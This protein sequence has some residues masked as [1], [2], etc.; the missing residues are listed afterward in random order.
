MRTFA[1]FHGKSVRGSLGE[2]LGEVAD[3]VVD[4]SSG[5]IPY[6]LVASRIAPTEGYRLRLV[7]TGALKESERGDGL[8]VP[9]QGAQ[10]RGLES[11]DARQLEAGALRAFEAH[12]QELARVFGLTQAGAPPSRLLLATHLL[13]KSVRHGGDT[14]GTLKAILAAS[15]RRT[16][17][18]L[19]RMVDSSQPRTVRVRLTEL[20]LPYFS[21][22]HFTTDLTRQE[23]ENAPAADINLTAALSVSA[24]VRQILNASMLPQFSTAGQTGYAISPV[25]PPGGP[26]PVPVPPVADTPPSPSGDDRLTPTGQSSAQSNTAAIEAALAAVRRALQAEPALQGSSVEVEVRAG[27]VV[28]RGKVPN[29]EL[30]QRAEAVAKRTVPNVPLDNEIVVPPR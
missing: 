19:V 1:N 15:D 30:R 16:A 20:R 2:K 24:D 13:G 6:V 26:G 3:V 21:A 23:L 29:A 12:R 25:V 14:L 10:W 11:I 28:L 5:E 7:P 9:F 17:V 27:R 18:A 4:V 22:D 8:M